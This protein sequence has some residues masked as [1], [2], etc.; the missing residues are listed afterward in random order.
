[1]RLFY[2]NG[3]KEVKEIMPPRKQFTR[4]QIIDFAF[5][6]AKEEG[7]AGITARKVASRMGSSVAPIYVNFKDIEELKKAVMGKLWELN[8]QMAQERYSDY[9]FLNVGIAGLRFAREYRVLFQDLMLNNNDYL[10]EY[11]QQAMREIVQELSKDPDFA[12]LNEEVIRDFI[13]KMQVFQFGLAVMVAYKK[14]PEEYDEEAQVKLLAS[15]GED[16]ITAARMRQEENKHS[17]P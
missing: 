6:V 17:R 16:V 5:D 1:M 10:D 13:L 12:G 7:L 15:I 8:Q 14:L 4:Q 11:Q 9:W 2:F 3:R